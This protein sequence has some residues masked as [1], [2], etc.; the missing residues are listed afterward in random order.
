MDA[1]IGIG[2][3]QLALEG[4]K[5]GQGAID[6]FLGRN[7][8]ANL[9]TQLK[10]AVRQNVRVP[11]EKRRE[12]AN[13]A[14]D[15][16]VDPWVLG[17]LR[18]YLFDGRADLL[19]LIQER[20]AEIYDVGGV[21]FGLAPAEIAEL[22]VGHI[23]DRGFLAIKDE[24]SAQHHEHQVT[25]N[26]MASSFTELQS[27]VRTPSK[28]FLLTDP[29]LAVA[30]AVRA[31]ST[32]AS[33][34]L[35]LVGHLIG[36]PSAGGQAAAMILE[37][38]QAL[39][40][41]SYH[42]WVF[43]V[44]QA[45]QV[46][47]FDAAAVGWEQ[48]STL[49]GGHAKSL[50]NAAIVASIAGDDERS[51]RLLDEA[52]S[53]DRNEPKLLIELADRKDS[54]EEK[55]AALE[56]VT[57][58]DQQEQA[59]I[60]CHRCLWHLNLDQ[61]DEAEA[62]ASAATEIAPEMLQVRMVTANTTIERGREA[63]RVGR[64][65]N[66]PELKGAEDACVAIRQELLSQRRLGESV[67]TLMLASD[68]A[69]LRYNRQ[70]AVELLKSATEDELRYR[71]GAIVLGDAAMRAQDWAFALRAAGFGDPADPQIKRIRASALYLMIG[72]DEPRE[73][74]LDL[75]RAG[76]ADGGVAAFTLL[77]HSGIRGSEWSD[78]AEAA[79]RPEDRHFVLTL[80]AMH[81]GEA[82]DLDGAR[83]LL[84]P[85]EHE[86]WAKQALFQV[87]RMRNEVDEQLARDTLATNPDAWVG[88]EAARMLVRAG[89]AREVEGYV[90][91]IAENEWIADEFRSEAI[92]VM[93]EVIQAESRWDEAE[94]WFERWQTIEAPD[95]LIGLWR[96]RVGNRRARDAG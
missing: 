43:L 7:D 37:P 34:D 79:V 12:L 89:F 90:R 61:L 64:P 60:H 72:T 52:K 91:S 62:E 82:G 68:A 46:G 59:L 88:V 23:E 24:R 11:D 35:A 3:A 36:E 54:F 10:R 21:D 14:S 29:P 74:L 49:R 40:E 28:L 69:A 95:A 26:L 65:R 87:V 85:D 71:D 80:K 93:L 6:S 5:L 39:Q 1:E 56:G 9:F 73:Q 30:K 2:A 42:A 77:M 67:R 50:V 86:D 58:D 31:L 18:S 19:P 15:L 38:S 45:E 32:E 75:V 4:F 81:R 16:R 83:A 8:I 76:G 20:I 22:I 53:V 96:A 47:R 51:A 33:Q 94:R 13:S 92:D 55:F 84:Q 78:E 41:A 57:S 66:G 25:R 27:E 17:A 70:G 44:R 48:I 63:F